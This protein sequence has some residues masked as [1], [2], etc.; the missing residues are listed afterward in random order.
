MFSKT[1]V[2]RRAYDILRND[3][4]L[5]VG[6]SA[7]RVIY[8]KYVGRLVIPLRYMYN[9]CIYDAVAHPYKV[10]HVS[11]RRIRRRARPFGFTDS[12]ARIAGGTWDVKAEPLTEFPKYNAVRM[13]YEDGIDWEETGIYDHLLAEIERKGMKD[14]CRNR[15][16]LK[17]RYA[18]ID[19]L[20]Q[21]MKSNGYDGSYHDEPPPWWGYSHDD[22]I[23]VHIGRDG[24]FIFAASG[25]HRLSISKVLDI[26]RIPVWV[27][28]RHRRWQTLREEMYTTSSAAALSDEASQY[29][30]H[31]DMQDVV[32]DDILDE[33]RD[34][35]WPTRNPP[36]K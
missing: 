25:W 27:R 33:T 13:R 3:G 5:S 36:T 29:I 2:F 1:T 8:K 4:P 32:A 28:A 30:H 17:R 19:A 11:P 12:I 21:S 22:Y 31:P 15:S 14:G 16:D 7:K 23:G 34:D 18:E 10:V 26:D 24:E 9:T 6:R 20:Y 35:Y